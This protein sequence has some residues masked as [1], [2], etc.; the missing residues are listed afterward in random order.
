MD[1]NQATIQQNIDFDFLLSNREA[2]D[3]FIAQHA[4]YIANLKAQEIARQRGI[5]NPTKIAELEVEIKDQ[6]IKSYVQAQNNGD[7]SFILGK[8][9]SLTHF[10]E[11]KKAY[12]NPRSS[13]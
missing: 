10:E 9:I 4:P 3:K 1:L 12:K 6:I 8:L 7:E 2:C 5:T 11:L 13:S